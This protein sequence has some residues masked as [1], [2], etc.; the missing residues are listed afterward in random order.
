MSIEK[1]TIKIPREPDTRIREVFKKQGLI[2]SAKMS[3]YSSRYP[4]GDMR[5][6]PQLDKG[7]RKDKIETIRIRRKGLGFIS[8]KEDVL[9]TLFVK[10]LAMN[11]IPMEGIRI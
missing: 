9:K 3:V 5:I 6:D 4:A 2:S 1:V 8:P 10:R 7:L 11:D